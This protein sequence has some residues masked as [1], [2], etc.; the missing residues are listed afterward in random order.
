M[1]TPRTNLIG[2]AGVA[3]TIFGAA[4]TPAWAQ[5]DAAQQPAEAPSAAAGDATDSAAGAP[6]GDEGA[7]ADPLI[8]TVNGTEI[9]QSDVQAM[10]AALP[11]QM[12]Q[13]PPQTVASLAIEQLVTRELILQE[14]QAQN[15]ADDPEVR[16]LIAR[17]VERLT[18]QAI[19]QTWLE[20]QLAQDVDPARLQQEFERYQAE[21]PESE[22]TLERLRPQLE[23]AVRQ[24]LVNELAQALR[25]D[26][27]VIFYDESGQPIEQ[28][29]DPARPADGDDDAQDAATQPDA[30]PE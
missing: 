20:R 3:L 22:E 7:A 9:R 28:A 30:A 10:F 24:Q 8:A 13:L 15:Y 4:A 2:A 11:P 27:A 1:K 5:D 26:A 18:E 12:R 23:Q 6:T 16:D 17:M 29:A 21:N 14:A 19:V 25:A